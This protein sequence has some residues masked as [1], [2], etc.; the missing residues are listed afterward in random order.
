MLEDPGAVDRLGGDLAWQ[1]EQ[2]LIRAA[3][4][5][6][7]AAREA[8]TR[9]LGLLRAE[10]AGPSPTPLERLLV[11]RVAACWLQ[12]HYADIFLAQQMGNLTL[13][14]GEYHQRSRDRAHGR[15][16]TSIK[17]LAAVRKLAV[18]VLQVNIARKQVN[19]VGGCPG[20]GCDEETR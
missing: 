15:Y 3:V 2:S 5:E 19:V 12:L 4:G 8:L 20:A 1:A 10:L 6:D 9:K 7:L 13:A 18:P 14:Q 16:L 11:E 17:T